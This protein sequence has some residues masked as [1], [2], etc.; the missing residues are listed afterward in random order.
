MYLLF[1][2][3]KRMFTNHGPTSRLRRACVAMIMAESLTCGVFLYRFVI[4]HHLHRVVLLL[5]LVFWRST[6][7][8]PLTIPAW[9]KVWWNRDRITCGVLSANVRRPD[10]HTAKRNTLAHI[11]RYVRSVFLTCVHRVCV[12]KQEKKRQQFLLWCGTR[13]LP[14]SGAQNWENPPTAAH[15]E[16]YTLGVRL[17]VPRFQLWDWQGEWV[18]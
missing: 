11:F 17:D 12:C 15:W 18:V 9:I 16:E 14:S 13:L 1:R 3:Y 5:G 8:L 2:C 6:E 10:S 7:W 4:V